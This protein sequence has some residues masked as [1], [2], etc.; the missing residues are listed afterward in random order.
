MQLILSHK[1]REKFRDEFDRRHLATQERQ[2]VDVEKGIETILGVQRRY[3]NMANKQRDQNPEL[4]TSAKLEELV[5]FQIVKKVH[6]DLKH[7]LQPA[8]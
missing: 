5:D 1:L 2:H 8:A 4:A 3:I 7:L 6:E